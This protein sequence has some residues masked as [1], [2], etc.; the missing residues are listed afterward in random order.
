MADF[1]SK[2]VKVPGFPFK[3][4]IP[5]AMKSSVSQSTSVLS[6]TLGSQDEHWGVP[7]SLVGQVGSVCIFH[8]QLQLAQIKTLYASGRLV[9]VSCLN[10]ALFDNSR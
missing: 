3:L 8:D 10:L 6:L 7:F 1:K 9:D 4:P 2:L 5:S